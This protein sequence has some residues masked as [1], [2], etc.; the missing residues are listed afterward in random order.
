MRKI[1][2]L[3]F[4]YN[5]KIHYEWKTVLIKSEKDY[6]LVKGQLDRKLVHH[7]KNRVFNCPNKSIE[8]FSLKEGFTVNIDIDDSGQAEYYCNI[9]LPAEFNSLNN[10]V[11]FIDLDLDLL[12]DNN[13]NKKVVDEDEFFSNSVAMNYP[14]ETID[15]ARNSLNK[16]E[17][18]ILHKKFPF[19][20]FFDYHIEQLL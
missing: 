10:T 19:D 1:D 15:Y 2:I 16:L 5:R 17:K 9:C 7:T 13:G 3:V 20:G 11:S 8:F 18:R 12:I 6:V 4:K 14:Q